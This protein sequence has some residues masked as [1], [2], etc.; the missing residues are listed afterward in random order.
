MR[1]D[2][3]NVKNTI[4][5]IYFLLV[6]LAVMLATVFNSF[7]IFEGSSLF[8]IIGLL[9]AFVIVHFIARYFEYDSDGSKLVITNSGLILTQFLNYREDQLEISKD[10]LVGFKIHNYYIYRT[11]VVAVQSK[12]KSIRKERFNITLLRRKKLKYVKQSL[13]KILKENIKLK[14]GIDVRRT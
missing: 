13:R 2:N 14:E 6:V 4:I 8:V 11:L 10:Q 9:V 12:N 3:R 1:T 5:S 7:H